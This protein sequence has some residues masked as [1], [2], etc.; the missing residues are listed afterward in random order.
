MNAALNFPI[1]FATKYWGSPAFVKVTPNGDN[2][3]VQINDQH[4][5]LLSHR[6]NDEWVDV[7]ERFEDSEMI[8]EITRRIKASI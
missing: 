7:Q 6:D 3:D 4:I 1:M 8:D 5:A 2:F